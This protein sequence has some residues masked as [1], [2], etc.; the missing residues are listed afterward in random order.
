MK[1][2]FSVLLCMSFGRIG[3]ANDL[4]YCELSKGWIP[5]HSANLPASLQKTSKEHCTEIVL[6][7]L[8]SREFASQY[9][10]P[11]NLPICREDDENT[12]SFFWKDE[13]FLSGVS[14]RIIGILQ[15]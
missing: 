13:V 12:V 2:I 3:L 5:G 1:Y 10:H 11:Q 9:W 7:G 4:A 8:A 15:K 6:R 14:C